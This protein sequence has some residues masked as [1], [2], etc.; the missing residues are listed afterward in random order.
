MPKDLEELSREIDILLSREDRK[1]PEFRLALV[2]SQIGSLASYLTHDPV[3]NPNA[4]P[5]GSREDELMAYG[6][7]FAMLMSLARARGINIEN[8]IELGIANWKDQDW[9]KR[10]SETNGNYLEGI[11]AC[12]GNITGEAFL[13]VYGKNLD[14]SSGYILITR[15]AT[16]EISSYLPKLAGVVTDHG[17]QT[18]H[19]AQL[20]RG[21]GKPPCV[22]GT[23]N[24]TKKISHGQKITIDAGSERDSGRVYLL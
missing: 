8:S 1:D 11:S 17:G 15:H 6:Q 19:L 5:H 2:M 14:K 7:A 22:V 23:G 20:A 4:R 16:P 24:A 18:C 12:P 3:L 13:D 21:Y 9:K 10:I